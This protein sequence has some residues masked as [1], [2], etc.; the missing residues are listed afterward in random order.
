MVLVMV[1][2]FTKN[3]TKW[4]QPSPKLG[5]GPSGSYPPPPT[6]NPPPP[7]P[8]PTFQAN[9]MMS[10]LSLCICARCF[11]LFL[12]YW[13]DLHILPSLEEDFTQSHGW[14]LGGEGDPRFP[15]RVQLSPLPTHMNPQDPTRPGGPEGGIHL[16][17]LEKHDQKSKMSEP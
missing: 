6:P 17:V 1:L 9:P 4:T 12:L 13:K 7:G 16:Y 14:W 5:P 3:E 8:P 10:F 2:L 11:P 15:R